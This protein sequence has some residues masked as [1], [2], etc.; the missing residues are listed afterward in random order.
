[1]HGDTFM[2]GN[3]VLLSAFFKKSLHR[4]KDMHIFCAGYRITVW[5]WLGTPAAPPFGVSG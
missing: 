4:W 2:H 3:T 5:L 1:M